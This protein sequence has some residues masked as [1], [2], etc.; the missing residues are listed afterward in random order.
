MDIKGPRVLKGFNAIVDG[1]G[2]LGKVEEIELPKLTVKT[3]EFRA[4]GMDAPVELD[5]GM[6]KLECSF[7][8]ADMSADVMISFGL[9]HNQPVAL[10]FRGALGTGDESA[11]AAV[12]KAQGMIKELD[13]GT[14]KAGEKLQQKVSIALKY[15]RYDEDGSLVHEI[16]IENMVRIIDGVDM[17]AATKSA[18]GG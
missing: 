9:G 1:R 12:V 13:H 3:E 16:D 2:Y 5:V 8:L 7:T 6:E 10:T 17:L 4:G 11:V 15:Y 14:W 18:I